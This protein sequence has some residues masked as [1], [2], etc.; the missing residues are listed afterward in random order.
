M[1]A[2]DYET[3]VLS[4]D[5][6][7][8][9]TL[10]TTANYSYATGAGMFRDNYIRLMSGVDLATTFTVNDATNLAVGMRVEST[11]T[12]TDCYIL[13]INGLTITVDVPLIATDTNVST[14]FSV[15]NCG[16][17][18]QK[19]SLAPGFDPARSYRGPVLRTVTVSNAGGDGVYIGGE[20]NQWWFED[21]QVIFG[22][23]SGV[24]INS[25]SD[26]QGSG[27]LS[28]SNVRS[29]LK[30]GTS[31]TPRFL[32]SEFWTG[33]NPDKSSEIEV[34]GCLAFQFISGEVNGKVKVTPNLTRTWHG[35][36]FVNV[37]FIYG[38]ASTLADGTPPDGLIIVDS[39]DGVSA[40]NCYFT[41]GATTPP[42]Y[43]VFFEDGNGSANLFGGLQPATP[44]ER[45]WTVGLT[46][47]PD[48]LSY[49]YWDPETN[50]RT[51]KAS[52]LEIDAT[53]GGTV[54][55]TLN[56]RTTIGNTLDFKYAGNEVGNAT[57]NSVRASLETPGGKGWG[58]E[59]PGPF[60]DDA[61]A[62]ADNIIVGHAYFLAGGGVV[63]RLV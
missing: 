38:E 33:T 12:R 19:E 57:V 22:N 45:V 47:N 62:A 7:T 61:A 13:D 48:Q 6:G 63:V 59:I 8:Q 56:R 34:N 17:F 58:L 2:F 53:G 29:A 30:V 36:R 1:E 44:S 60:A 4:I 42:D 26:G 18:A 54:A 15:F 14:N 10:S 16:I 51:M 50:N 5:S 20:R 40:E 21:L 55:L 32:R 39:T 37:N 3:T 11:M 9:F 52:R 25:A 41:N 28:G 24:R 49:V 31:A 27:V 46:N 23:A 35:V 43:L